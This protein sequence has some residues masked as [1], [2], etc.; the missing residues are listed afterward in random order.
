MNKKTTKVLGIPLVSN[1]KTILK[2]AWSIR[3]YAIA[4]L[5][6]AMEAVLPILDGMYEIPRGIFAFASFI[7][8]VAGF[9]LRLVAQNSIPN[10]EVT[11]DVQDTS[12]P[13]QE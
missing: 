12:K 9:I 13:V 11:T 6:T 8:I 5:F 4:G 7:S 10:P 1:W 2:K 3:L